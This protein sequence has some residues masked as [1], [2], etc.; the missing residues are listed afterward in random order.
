[1]KVSAH[2]RITV[3]QVIVCLFSQT[4]PSWLIFFHLD[5]NACEEGEDLS[6]QR[7]VHRQSR[8]AKLKC[9]QLV[10]GEVGLGYGIPRVTSALWTKKNHMKIK[11]S[12]AL[13]P[14]ETWPFPRSWVSLTDD[15]MNS[16]NQSHLFTLFC[17]SNLPFPPQ[18]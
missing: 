3:V 9:Q 18:V 11:A 7:D 17:T 4:K 10:C 15:F 6:P 5:W 12:V 1:M 13:P 16:C 14:Q 8:A 2:R